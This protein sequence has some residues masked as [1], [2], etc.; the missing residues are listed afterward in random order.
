M[1]ASEAQRSGANPARPLRRTAAAI[2]R[3]ASVPTAPSPSSAAPRVRW[4]RTQSRYSYA[5]CRCSPR[6]P[7]RSCPAPHAAAASS[8]VIRPSNKVTLRAENAC[9]KSMFQLFQ[10]FHVDVAKVDRDVAYVAM[11]VHVCCKFLFS[12]FHLF[13]QTYV[14]SVFI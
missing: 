2:P 8:S 3:G 1:T 6:P 4:P 13:F 9:C 12:V 14:A 11:V 7:S 10:I 5:S